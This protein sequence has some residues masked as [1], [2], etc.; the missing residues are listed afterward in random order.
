MALSKGLRNTLFPEKLSGCSPLVARYDCRAGF[1]NLGTIDI[2]D[3]IILCFEGLSCAL[4][5]IEQPSWAL[6][7]RCRSCLPPSDHNQKCVQILPNVPWR[8]PT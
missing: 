4:Q 6:P 7:S 3:G 5:D 2:L 8:E 1:F